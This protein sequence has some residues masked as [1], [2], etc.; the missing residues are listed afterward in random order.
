M[1]F[2]GGYSL[3]SLHKTLHTLYSKNFIPILDYAK[4]S[5]HNPIDVLKY[6]SKMN[7]MI[8]ETRNYK[9]IAYACKLSSFLPY[10]PLEHIK[11]INSNVSTLFLDAE[12]SYLN[13]EEG[14]IYKQLYENPTKGEFIYKTYQMYR[15]DGLQELLK[16]LDTY[17]EINIKLVRGAYHSKYDNKLFQSK[18]ETDTNY[19]EALKLLSLHLK[20]NK[21]AKICI[22]THNENSINLSCDLFKENKSNISFAQL[23]DMRDDL[24]S[25]LVK[26]DF[27]VY[28][29]VP[30]GTFQE[31]SPYLIRRLYENKNIL[32]HIIR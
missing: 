8:N 31:T 22:A 6:M 19:D 25:K 7:D 10:K 12:Q 24:S 20:K 23:L 14:E 2:I 15:R 1:K 18:L 32:N 17:P 29:Y 3:T 28:K 11:L 13:N 26:N 9:D 5:S 4:E 30:Y 27:K 16:D 21:V